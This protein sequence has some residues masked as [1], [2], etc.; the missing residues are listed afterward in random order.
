MNGMSGENI[1][2]AATSSHRRSIWPWLVGVVVLYVGSIP[3]F[4]RFDQSGILKRGSWQWRIGQVY[5]F[6]WVA[7]L[8]NS[9]DP[10]QRTLWRYTLLLSRGDWNP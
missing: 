10:I 4:V 7:L 8:E 1:I 3:L 5:C 6:P 2:S 9:P